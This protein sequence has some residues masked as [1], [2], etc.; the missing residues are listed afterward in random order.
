[1]REL[2]DAGFEQVGGRKPFLT[3][4]E[5]VPE[6]PAITGYPEG[7]MVAAW[8]FSLGA[9]F[10]AVLTT[11]SND[12]ESPDDFEGFIRA[13]DPASNGYA[14]GGRCVNYIVSHDHESPHAAAR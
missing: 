5:H 14:S 6:D 3:V 7:P 8:R 10:R 2:T 1:M 4:A 13:L 9:H 12:G 11:K